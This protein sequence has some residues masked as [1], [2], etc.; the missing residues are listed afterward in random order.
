MT[1][2]ELAQIVYVMLA[3]YNGASHSGLGGRTPLE[4]MRYWLKKPG[5]AIRQLPSHKRKQL[6]LLQ[7]ARIVSIVGGSKTGRQPHINFESVRYTSDLLKGKP[8]LIGKKL[9]IY[10]NIKDIRQIHAFFEDGSELGALIASKSWRKTA[11]SL[12]LRKEILRLVR[13][14]KLR[15]REGD[16][17]I[18]AWAVYKRRAAASDK[19]A[20]SALARQ[21]QVQSAALT[22]RAAV[23]IRDAER[24]QVPSTRDPASSEDRIGSGSAQRKEEASVTGAEAVGLSQP[25]PLR[26][27]RTIVFGGNR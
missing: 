8:E 12:R 17:A 2:D 19:R 27:R 10:F 3:D 23:G 20:A 18:E 26:V 16:D 4:A 22:F 1:V 15:Y 11:H 5:A 24:D 7:D 13:L 21:Q 25:R 6:M 9:K 14:G